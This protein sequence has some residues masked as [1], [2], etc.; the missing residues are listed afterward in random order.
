MKNILYLG[1]LLVA[2]A[3]CTPQAES[4]DIYLQKRVGIKREYGSMKGFSE[5]D[6]TTLMGRML[7]DVKV[8][9]VGLTDVKYYYGETNFP[10]LL[11][12]SYRQGIIAKDECMEYFDAWGTIDTLAMSPEPLKVF[13]VAAIGQ[14]ADNEKCIVF[15]GNAN[16]DLSDD[17][18]M[19]YGNQHPV[20]LYHE[21]YIGG[22]I[23]P[24][25]TYVYTDE[26]MMG[27]TLKAT[28]WAEQ[29]ITLKGR[30]YDLYIDNLGMNYDGNTSLNFSTPYHTY[31]YRS[32]QY[33][34]LADSYYLIDSLSPDGRY[35]HLTEVPDAGAK[36]V[37]QK[38]FRVCSFSTTDVEG[39]AVNFPDGFKGKYVLLDFWATTCG[40]CV[41]DIKNKYGSLY[42]KYHEAGFEIL[43][44]ADDTSEDIRRFKE[45]H[46]VPWITVADRDHGSEL[47]K[48]FGIETFPTLYLIGPDGR[49]VAEGMEARVRLEDLLAR[50]LKVE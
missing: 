22:R 50:Y 11:Y 24:D 36:E 18:L 44:I 19:P 48:R 49:I 38:G 39:N 21:R 23:V 40:A 30:E 3:S 35:M 47:I 15:D 26:R 12:Q 14:N 17:E 25:T 5:K 32:G 9:P 8:P 28:E 10:Q 1:G 37:M 45:N 31:T 6:T 34:V 7:P 27:L 2:M 33:A 41:Q 20:P 16:L 29:K 42:E 46:S 4:I 13:V 43:G